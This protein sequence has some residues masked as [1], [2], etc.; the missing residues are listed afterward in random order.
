MTAT[1][2]WEQRRLIAGL[3]HSWAHQTGHESMHLQSSALVK[4]EGI[5][6]DFIK[7]STRKYG[8]VIRGLVE[9]E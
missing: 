4:E 9:Y 6:R 2:T 8:Y 3:A 5:R 1:L 7:H